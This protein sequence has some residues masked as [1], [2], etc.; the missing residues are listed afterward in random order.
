LLLVARILKQATKNVEIFGD[1]SLDLVHRPTVR[2]QVQMYCSIGPVMAFLNNNR[3][4][5][6]THRLRKR[7]SEAFMSP[8]L[9]EELAPCPYDRWCIGIVIG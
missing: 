4:E 2:R 7:A 3:K 9:P 6:K 1:S 5:K 8:L